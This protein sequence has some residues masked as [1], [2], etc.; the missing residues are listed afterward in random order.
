M[1]PIED[2][3]R[4]PANTDQ[5]LLIYLEDLM[6]QRSVYRQAEAIIEE[7]IG[8]L[9]YRPPGGGCSELPLEISIDD[10][11][12]AGRQVVIVSDCNLRPGWESIAFAWDERRQG[13]P[14]GFED[15]PSCGPDHT[16]GQYNA[17]L[18]R[19]WEDATQLTATA[20]DPDDGIP[21]PTAA[22][23]A[24]CGV[25]LIGLDHITPFDGR[26]RRMVWSWA[27]GQPR[28]G[29]CALMRLRGDRP[30]W[31]WG[32]WVSRPCRGVR[33][34][35]ACLRRGAWRIVARKVAGWRAARACRRAGGRLAVP[36][37]GHENQR[38]RLRMERR[39]VRAAWLGY[40][41]RVGDWRALDLR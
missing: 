26:L 35:A 36:R 34:P 14:F 25:N 13:R 4:R 23:M 20:G 40:S 18:I 30:S 19:Y 12:A 31:E 6:Q 22:A 3:L 38:L 27:P 24:R 16:R 33:R 15:F 37:T 41:K 8:D 7:R 10:V 5:V 32:R 21:P 29:R 9:I 1:A 11:R 2:W 39:G 17:H 28:A